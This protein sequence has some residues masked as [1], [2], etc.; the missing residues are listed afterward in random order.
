M[1]ADDV[2][3]DEDTTEMLRAIKE[4][5][6]TQSCIEIKRIQALRAGDEAKSS[7]PLLKAINDLKVIQHKA[8]QKKENR[9]KLAKQL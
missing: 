2:K 8:F 7:D 4:Y 3:M 6:P 1:F 9:D 5:K